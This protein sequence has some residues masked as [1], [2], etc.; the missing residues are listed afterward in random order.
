MDKSFGGRGAEGIQTLRKT[1]DGGYVFIGYAK[2][3]DGQVS[4]VY[5]SAI[6]HYYYY[7]EIDVYAYEPDLWL[8]KLDANFNVSWSKTFGGSL[9][10][11]GQ[12]I[13]VQNDGIIVIGQIN[14][15]NG[16]VPRPTDKGSLWVAKFSFYGQIMW[17]TFPSTKPTYGASKVTQTTDNNL[18]IVTTDIENNDYGISAIK[19][20]NSGTLLWQ[21]RYGGTASDT[22]VD[23]VKNGNRIII[24][25][26]TRSGGT[27]DVPE[28]SSFEDSW[29]FSIDN[30]G[31]ILSNFTKSAEFNKLASDGTNYYLFNGDGSL[32]SINKYDQYS[33]LIW[34]KYYD[35][36]TPLDVVKYDTNHM[37]LLSKTFR[38]DGNI[39]G[40]KKFGQSDL[41]L[42]K[43]NIE[44][45]E[46]VWSKIIGGSGAEGPTE[47]HG[48][49]NAS[50]I[51]DHQNQILVS[52]NTNSTDHD[53]SQTLS[54]P[55]YLFLHDAWIAQFEKEFNHSGYQIDSLSK[56]SYCV[57]DS[58]LLHYS[59]TNQRNFECEISN[60]KGQFDDI[61]KINISGESPLK[62]PVPDDETFEY[63]YGYKIKMKSLSDG[64]VSANLSEDFAINT[65]VKATIFSKDS[66]IS[67]NRNY[68]YSVSLE[69]GPPIS[70][71]L[72]ANKWRQKNFRDYNTATYFSDLNILDPDTTTTV[73][74]ITELK[75]SCGYNRDTISFTIQKE[76]CSLGGGGGNSS[77]NP[78]YFT[79]KDEE[80]KH[81]ININSSNNISKSYEYL[82]EQNIELVLGDLYYMEDLSEAFDRFGQPTNFSLSVWLDM[83]FNGIFDSSE[84]IYSG[85]ST[86][87]NDGKSLLRGLFPIPAEVKYG[88]TRMRIVSSEYDNPCDSGGW[89]RDIS[90]NLK[91]ASSN[92]IGVRIPDNVPPFCT[93]KT[94]KLPLFS[95]G[96]IPLPSSLTF[97]ISNSS[98]NF[99][100][101]SPINGIIEND[102]LEFYLDSTFNVGSNYKIKIVRP[103]KNISTPTSMPFVINSI[104]KVELIGS[105]E[106]IKSGTKI[107]FLVN[108][109]G[110][111]NSHY[112]VDKSWTHSAINAVYLQNNRQENFYPDSDGEYYVRKLENN[113]GI[114][115]RSNSII[116][117]IDE[118][119]CSPRGGGP[120][121]GH[122]KYIPISKFIVKDSMSNNDI[123][124]KE[125]QTN[126][127]GYKLYNEVYKITSGGTYSFQLEATS[128]WVDD[129]FNNGFYETN[130]QSFM[131]WIDKNH[132][133]IFS[134]TEVLYQNL[135]SEMN[136]SFQGFFT[137]PKDFPSGLT[138]LRVRAW[139]G[140]LP[141]F[142]Y[143]CAITSVNYISET[144]DYWLDISDCKENFS[145]Q[146]L[147]DNVSIESKS[148]GYLSLENSLITNSQV[149]LQAENY[150]LVKPPFQINSG[151]VFKASISGCN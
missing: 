13:L 17:R 54:D 21:R 39:Y 43:V 36:N 65:P 86:L 11:T 38:E 103:N 45:G 71:N 136:P 28:Q 115:E 6:N 60:N 82:S 57:G 88:I 19:L 63:G 35:G 114:S 107:S 134:S 118:N 77:Y 87:L 80:D 25:A 46:I 126:M 111:A 137:I 100:D 20:N 83:N 133:N 72:N 138:R 33:N 94:V 129:Y 30:S 48:L 50:V 85:S 24:G 142:D 96:N 105:S 56:K 68:E 90:V 99:L 53:I 74:Y 10:D 44:F 34:T 146:S 95:T 81:L 109:Q 52:A 23:L 64:T 93:K 106:F 12:D 59:G 4:G 69:G 144:E 9:S 61:Y 7:P 70:G 15:T 76:Y 1:P 47:V 31:N 73:L 98:G 124:Y 79:L 123:I 108:V 125:S 113:C 132:D 8:V 131:I 40:K 130:P 75:N 58:I 41:W 135:N 120:D 67:Q 84:K 78:Q 104:P 147:V 89:A 5:P 139:D 117:K 16:K 37:L 121:N 101:S 149:K 116:I 127:F 151:T 62:I 2:S 49:G 122:M 92:S 32:F 97:R 102:S 141:E 119:S 18:L 22:F 14:S 27:G 55:R 143:P 112:I 42:M 66:L 3:N 150:I 140:R 110:S 91:P 29:I 51:L 145:L 128:R 148:R 26:H